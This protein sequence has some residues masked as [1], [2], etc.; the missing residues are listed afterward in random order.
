MP[1]A[2]AWLSTRGLYALPMT[3]PLRGVAVLAALLSLATACGH[4]PEPAASGPAAIDRD[5][6]DVTV[7]QLHKLYA[8]KKYTVTQVVQ[9]HLDRID[10][11]N[12]VYG[13]IET[14]LRSS[15]LAEAK[16]QDAFPATANGNMPRPLWGVPIVIK[17]NTSIKGEVTTAGW[18]GF[19]RAGHELIAPQD[20]T[21]VARFKA[22]GAIIVGIANMPDLA[23]SDTNRSSSYGRTGNA[24]DVRFSP[25]GSS[26]GIVTAIAANMA[27]LGNGTDTGNSI[28]M[29][30]ATS[31]LVGV[32]PT[33]G[34]V[35]I[36]G[37]APLDWLLDNTGPIARTAT[38]AAIALSVMAGAEADPLDPKTSEASAGAR[39]VADQSH[40]KADALKGKRF[41]V[42]AFV[43]AGDGIPFH[44]IPSSV[45]EPAFEKLRT[46]AN[47]PL[48]PETRAMF[49]KAVEALRSAGAEVVIDDG[50]LPLSFAKLATRVS[51]YAYMQDGTNRFLS[52]FG[53]P[54][55]HSAADYLKAAGSPLFTSSIGTE[56]NFRHLG[57]IH[58]YQRVLDKDPDAER[59]Y[60]APR[61][62]MLAAY[63]ETLDRLKLDGFVYPAI[64]MPPPDETMPQDGRVSEGPHSATSWVNMIGVPAVVVPAG[65]YP[66]GLPFGLEFSARPWT[67]GDLLSIAYAWEQATH[68]RKPPVLVEKGL[69][70]VTPAREGRGPGR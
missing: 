33:R 15:A 39:P 14:V 69:L 43:L 38:D 58:I 34:L 55:Y 18:E 25:G 49:M 22:A 53:P 35:S 70:P 6:L 24:Y 50:I 41:G 27:V 28:R 4:A 32:F 51:T 13:A 10:R 60:L 44:G 42:P 2:A 47:T 63:V 46:T 36:A 37:I 68:L 67:D 16:R 12:G 64:Q 21:I 8:D 19:A 56:D 40:L 3:N 59:T 29:P 30:A 20:A 54:E 17:A 57:G 11:Y 1:P 31:A 65:F 66:S 48:R 5:L 7:P 62:A 9:W 23:N 45:P 61:R 26:G 52:T